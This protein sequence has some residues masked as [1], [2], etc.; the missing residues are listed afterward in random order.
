MGCFPNVSQPNPES[1]REYAAEQD[2][3]LTQCNEAIYKPAFLLHSPSLRPD[4]RA[5]PLLLLHLLDVGD[6]VLLGHVAL[7]GHDLLDQVVHVL[8]IGFNDTVV[9][10][11][12]FQT[13]LD[14]ISSS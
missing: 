2:V 5:V 12:T 11:E 1:R 8:Q 13:V 14:L 6:G 4:V 9:K 10:L 3:T 7:L